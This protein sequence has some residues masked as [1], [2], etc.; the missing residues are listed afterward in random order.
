MK[1]CESNVVASEDGFISIGLKLSVS[2]ETV[3]TEFTKALQESLKAYIET[4]C[5][6]AVRDIGILIVSAPAPAKQPRVM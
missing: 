1:E 4:Y 6:I 5:G 3:L 2:N